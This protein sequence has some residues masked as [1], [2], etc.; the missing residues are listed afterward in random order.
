MTDLASDIVRRSLHSGATDAECVVAEGE[1]FSANVR[2]GEV[3]SLKESGSK[4]LGLRVLIGLRSG[5]S[6]TSDF[7]PAGLDR[8]VESAVAL[9]R[10][11][12]ED[13]FA[14]L[15]QP[16]ELGSTDHDLGLYY[17]DVASLSA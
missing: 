9:A 3:E 1:E 17:E 15:P 13:P 12:S 16:E 14:G 8:L 6:Y 2:L 7:S 5:S 10:I 4:A 11:T